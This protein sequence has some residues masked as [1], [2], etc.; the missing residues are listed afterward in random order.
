MSSARVHAKT[1]TS[2]PQIRESKGL[3]PSRPADGWPQTAMFA[4]DHLLALDWRK[5]LT[6]ERPPAN[7][8]SISSKCCGLPVTLDLEKSLASSAVF[9]VSSGVNMYPAPLTGPVRLP[10]RPWDL[11]RRTRPALF[12]GGVPV[13]GHNGGNGRNGMSHVAY[14]ASKPCIRWPDTRL[15]YDSKMIQNRTRFA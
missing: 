4:P 14:T 11:A 1:L 5:T 9:S 10:R 13:G 6:N 2:S 3:R 15:R 8:V 7:S 12:G